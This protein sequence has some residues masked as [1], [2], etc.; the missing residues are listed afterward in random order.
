MSKRMSPSAWSISSTG[1]PLVDDQAKRIVE[2]SSSSRGQS[3]LL[4][5]NQ[6]CQ[7]SRCGGGSSNSSMCSNGVCSG[8]KNQ[9]A[10]ENESCYIQ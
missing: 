5:G 8:S 6:G 4:Q 10:C 2:L 3:G 1:V 7:N 9:F